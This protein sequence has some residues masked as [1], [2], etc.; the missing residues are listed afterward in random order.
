MQRRPPDPRTPLDRPAAS[1][2][3]DGGSAGG[4]EVYS[5]RPIGDLAPRVRVVQKISAGHVLAEI[6]YARQGP[7]DRV[8]CVLPKSLRGPAWLRHCCSLTKFAKDEVV[9][10][11]PGVAS[12]TRCF[13]RS[14]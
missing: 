8:Q 7:G 9:V 13:Y 6:E 5:D 4:R 10:F 11:L 2:P 3:Q 1:E 14:G 12:I